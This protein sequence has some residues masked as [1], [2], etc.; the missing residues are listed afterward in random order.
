MSR[1]PLAVALVG[2][3][4]IAAAALVVVILVLVNGSGGAGTATALIPTR[5][6]TPAA[7]TAT[8]LPSTW[9]DGLRAST[10]GTA[11]L[12]S[13]LDRNGDGRISGADDAAY[14]GLNIALTS[15]ACRDPQI[16][17]DFYAGPPSDPAQ[18]ACGLGARPVLLVAIASAGSNL[19][20]PSGGESMG[21]LRTVA[22]LQ[23]R[24]QAAGI[25]SET[26]LA[27]SAVFGAVQPQT[28][29]EQ[30][31]AQDLRARL[32]ARPCLRAVLIGH[33]HGAVT[34]T[35]VTAALD[36]DDGDR[37]LG[38]A[39]DRTTSLYDREATEYP[40]RTRILN[41]FQTNEGWHGSR[42]DLPNVV[43]F[44]ESAERAPVA[45][46]DGGGGL[47][48]VS[49]KTLDDAPEVQRAIAAAV[50][51]WLAVETPLP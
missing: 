21:V 36:R 47:A 37:M 27:M 13:C 35:S 8:P 49:H 6:P 1:G 23:D 3:V 45:L 2:A 29:M 10:G 26:V 7:A 28:A 12:I 44:D 30:W 22:D 51:R 25:S 48:L 18:A 41:F 42:V 11:I 40:E 31:L 38:I 5:T 15:D 17:R 24:M 33:S 34:V 50:M 39:V 19:L 20:D 32:A 14:D 46:S 43:N 16:R 4:A 9:M